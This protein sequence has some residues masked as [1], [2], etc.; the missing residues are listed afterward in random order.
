MVDY[1]LYLDE[2]GNHDLNK[3][4][5][6]HP[7]LC[8]C[9]CVFNKIHYQS[10][11]IPKFNELKMKYWNRTDV[12]LH[13]RDIRKRQGDFSIL[14][15][16]LTRNEFINDLDELISRIGFVVIAAVID[17]PQLKTKYQHNAYDPYELSFKFI[18]ER[19][20][21]F[22]E[23]NSAVGYALSESR[24]VTEDQALISLYEKFKKYGTGFKEIDKIH[25]FTTKKKS[26][27]I[28]GMQISDLVA[29][30]V[31]TKFIRPE[32]QNIAFDIIKNKFLYK[33]KKKKKIISG[34]GFK[35]FP[36]SEKCDVIFS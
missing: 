4:D 6:N 21:M 9:G 26:E 30:P 10:Y 5:P 17:I 11:I 32:K 16:D 7:V 35:I 33:V 19:F 1:I 3:V 12:I 31:A 20:S 27:N 34:V 18:L 28:I 15:N 14:N 29:Y 8:L 13:S 22:L 25:S 2:S 24:G 23:D 36:Y